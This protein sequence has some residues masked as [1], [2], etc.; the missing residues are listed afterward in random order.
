L[1]FSPQEIY[2]S[3]KKHFPNFEIE[4]QSD[5]RQAI[6]D[7]WPNSIDDSKASTDW[8]WKSKFNLEAM[9]SAIITNL[10]KYF[11]F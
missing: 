11:N 9:T 7:S 8:G 1:S 2:Q 6:A 5:F 3:I 10:P 4:Y